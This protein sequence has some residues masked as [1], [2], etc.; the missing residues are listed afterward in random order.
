VATTAV[1]AAGCRIPVDSAASIDGD[2]EIPVNKA[3]V[4]TGIKTFMAV[5][6]QLQ[7]RRRRFAVWRRWSN[8]AGGVDAATT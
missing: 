3:S 4:A 8:Q 6:L 2:P 7:E 5:R 1:I